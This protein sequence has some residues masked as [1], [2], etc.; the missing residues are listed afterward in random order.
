[1]YWQLGFLHNMVP[2]LRRALPDASTTR[3]GAFRF[4]NRHPKRQPAAAVVAGGEKNLQYL[5]RDSSR[6]RWLLHLYEA[7]GFD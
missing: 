4:G 2:A 1:M 3:S 6:T 5:V 7:E